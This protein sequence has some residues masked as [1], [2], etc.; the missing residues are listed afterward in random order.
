[1]TITAKHQPANSEQ[2]GDRRWYIHP[3]TGERFRSVT[4]ALSD[5]AKYGL[6]DWAAG[7][8]AKAAFERLDWLNRVADADNCNSTKT[9]DACGECPACCIAW[10]ASRHEEVRD[11]A[12]ELGRKLHDAAEEHALWGPGASIDPQVQP[13]FDQWLRW[14]D[15]WQVEFEAT[16]MT[17]ISR[18]WG[19]GGTLD[20]ILR[21][22]NADL[23][24]KQFRHLA[25][26]PVCGDYKTGKSV[27]IPKGWQVVAYSKADAVLLK[28]GTELP[29]PEIKGGMVIHIRPDKLQVREAHITEANFANFIHVLGMAEALDA[30]LNTVLSRPY[31]LPGENF[32]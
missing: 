17:V 14:R 15:A 6:I 3:I 9:D 26:L 25:G 13:F 5:I 16:E 31:T 22:D 29:M 28:D 18:K 23:L 7:L 21:V 19:Y 24:P 8:T 2:V 12:A 10:L 11:D 32:Q 20:T 27:D 4:T 30:G 1:M